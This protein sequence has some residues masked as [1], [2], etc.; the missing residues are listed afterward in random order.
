MKIGVYK[1]ENI[2]NENKHIFYHLVNL[3]YKYIFSIEV[4]LILWL[5][6]LQKLWF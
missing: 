5:I 1:H 3:V 4:P 2:F 6:F